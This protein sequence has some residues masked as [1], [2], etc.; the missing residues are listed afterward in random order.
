M[1]KPWSIYY[2]LAQEQLTGKEGKTALLYQGFHGWLT[3]K[4]IWER[5]ENTELLTVQGH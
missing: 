2:S 4:I 5:D 1:G 3:Q